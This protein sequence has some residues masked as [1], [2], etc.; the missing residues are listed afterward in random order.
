MS[1]TKLSRI[2]PFRTA[3]YKKQI[4][5]IRYQNLLWRCFE[6][7]IDPGFNRS[8]ID[9]TKWSFDEKKVDFARELMAFSCETRL[10]NVLPVLLGTRDNFANFLTGIGSVPLPVSSNKPWRQENIGIYTS[11]G[12]IGTSSSGFLRRWFVRAS[13]NSKTDPRS[14]KWYAII[15]TDSAD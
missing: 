12:R 2:I 14:D 9:V 13:L 15:D 4:Q 10:R 7:R 3:G 8:L 6:Q 1:K 5:F 11:A